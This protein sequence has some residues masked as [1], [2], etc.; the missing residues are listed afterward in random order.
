MLAEAPA[1]LFTLQQLFEQLND[2]IVSLGDEVVQ[3][4]RLLWDDTCER[5][6]SFERE[7]LDAEPDDL[8]GL[9]IQARTM[10]LILKEGL[11]IDLRDF[12]PFTERLAELAGSTAGEARP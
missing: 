5:R 12:E 10:V 3:N 7:I 1:P 8:A 4:D 2:L 11:D 9:V 6:I